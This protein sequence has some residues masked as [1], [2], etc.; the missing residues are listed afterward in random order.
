MPAAPEAEWEDA[1]KAWGSVICVSTADFDAPL[2]T[3]KQHIMSRFARFV[4]VLYVES[5]GLRTPR[6]SRQ[7]A[8][9][10]I[11]RAMSHS[12][13][14]KAADNTVSG[15]KPVVLAPRIIPL[16]SR[17]VYRRINRELLQRAL[18]PMLATFP[19]P[20]LLWSYS[21]VAVDEL[22]LDAFDTIVYHCVDDLSTVPGVIP[23]TITSTEPRMVE[24]ADAVFVSSDKLASKLRLCSSKTI[25]VVYNVAD[26]EHF[27]KSRSFATDEVPLD[28]ERIPP[29]RALMVGALSDHK[30]DWEL[31]T[32]LVRLRADWSFVFIGPR[33]DEVAMRGYKA[34]AGERNVA[35]LGHRP[36]SELPRY[37]RG[38]DAA[39]IP[40]RITTHTESVFPL[41]TWEYLAA[42]VHVVATRLPSLVAAAPPVSFAG[43]ADEF[44]AALELGH[45]VSPRQRAQAA[46]SHTWDTLLDSM[47]RQIPRP[48]STSGEQVFPSS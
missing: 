3:N 39:L 25:N 23:A 32:R 16:H 17:P 6:L 15:T 44:A 7:D 35:F 2:W 12:Q 30:I 47:F 38:A 9:R 11:R 1:I 20:R 48:F 19:K 24:R 43:D 28:L 34:I 26:Y 46:S 10:V 33:G 45:Q 8:R 37:L 41:K 27:A 36:Y 22:D 18:T 31:L 4:P 14:P 29:P 13:R 21:P 40:Y 42:G 5:L